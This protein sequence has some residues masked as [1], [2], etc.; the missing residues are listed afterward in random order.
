MFTMMYKTDIHV[1]VIT[2]PNF[3]GFES[4]ILYRCQWDSFYEIKV[5]LIIL[6]DQIYFHFYVEKMV[7]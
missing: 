6:I 3:R 7:A 5:Q 2:A 1:V 4:G